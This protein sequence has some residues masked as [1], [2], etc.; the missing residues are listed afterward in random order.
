MHVAVFV[1]ALSGQV[2]VDRSAVREVDVTVFQM[3]D[4]AL[5][6]GRCVVIRVENSLEV[7]H[8]DVNLIQQGFITLMKTL[9]INCPHFFSFLKEIKL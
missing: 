8:D 7:F 1:D 3:A 2:S 5:D 6:G 4:V 9:L